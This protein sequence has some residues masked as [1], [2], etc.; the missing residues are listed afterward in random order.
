MPHLRARRGSRYGVGR[1]ALVSVGQREVSAEA[2]GSTQ[3]LLLS[4]EAFR[5]LV[6]DAPRVGCRILESCVVEFAGVA[7]ETLDRMQFR[8]S[9]ST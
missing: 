3:V 6:E 7:R 1:V 4:R 8:N 5:R 2:A 9:D